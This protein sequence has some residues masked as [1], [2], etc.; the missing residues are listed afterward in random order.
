MLALRGARWESVAACFVD[1]CSRV[2]GSCAWRIAPWGGVVCNRCVGCVMG[3][4][5]TAR[6]GLGVRGGGE[7]R[8]GRLGRRFGG[9]TWLVFLVWERSGILWV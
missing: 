6:F 9:R 4:E 7:R 1:G 2:R 5:R 8:G 3:G